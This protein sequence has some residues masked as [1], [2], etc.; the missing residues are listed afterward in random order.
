[1]PPVTRAVTRS[2]ARSLT[3]AASA[4]PP[5]PRCP[6][7]SLHSSSPL[8]PL[9]TS[10][11]T[12][13]SENQGDGASL[14]M[15]QASDEDGDADADG[16]TD[17]E[18]G[19]DTHPNASPN[20]REPKGKEKADSHWGDSSQPDHSGDHGGVDEEDELDEE[21]MGDEDEQGYLDILVQRFAGGP[22]ALAE[23]R[24]QLEFY[25]AQKV[26][27]Q[28]SS[29]EVQR[30]EAPALSQASSPIAARESGVLFDST[31]SDVLHRRESNAPQSVLNEIHAKH[32][33]LGVVLTSNGKGG[34]EVCPAI[35][36]A[37]IKEAHPVP[38]NEL[39]DFM[40]EMKFISPVLCWCPRVAQFHVV[41]G[42]NS[43]A[44]GRTQLRCPGG[45]EGTCGYFVTLEWVVNKPRPVVLAIHHNRKTQ[46]FTTWKTAGV[47]LPEEAAL[48]VESTQNH[49]PSSCA[50]RVKALA[51][52][53][54]SYS[55]PAPS[56]TRM[57]SASHHGGGSLSSPVAGP[58]SF[59]KTPS[60]AKSLA[61]ASSTTASSPVKPGPPET[62]ASLPFTSPS[63][64]KK[65]APTPATPATH[66]FSSNKGTRRP[67]ASSSAISPLSVRSSGVKETDKR[68]SQ[69]RA[70]RYSLQ[71]I[72]SSSSNSDNF[73][74]LSSDPEDSPPP[75]CPIPS[76]VIEI[77]DSDDEKKG[78]GPM[79]KERQT[80]DHR[81]RTGQRLQALASDPTENPRHVLRRR[82]KAV[83][84]RNLL[85]GT[86]L[87]D[88]P[89]YTPGFMEY[90]DALAHT[91]TNTG[92]P[93]TEFYHWQQH[94]SFCPHCDS[95]FWL[96]TG[97]FHECYEG[98]AASELTKGQPGGA[99]RGG[100]SSQPNGSKSIKR[101]AAEEN[102][103]KGKG[104]GEE[105]HKRRKK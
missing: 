24:E 39:E 25:E 28:G 99:T 19:C 36:V 62:R 84:C 59:S 15:H 96:E 80:R 77:T 75:R 44:R 18:G 102:E 57:S 82:T 66:A 34:W 95:A 41:R 65:S 9:P 86:R 48:P 5:P 40:M 2:R 68:T 6:T 3:P 32:N 1:M 88:R 70:S 16:D 100:G 90:I 46:S 56:P 60:P 4:S 81:D 78:Q 64:K 8:T 52:G 91:T 31:L 101:K 98:Q 54:G 97:Q 83:D 50:A 47:S 89:H 13:V 29:V 94:F 7:S 42:P 21:G 23:Q 58:S 26:G 104:K 51:L 38:P 49:S 20:K 63:S 67:V 71:Y 87:P 53:E 73:I 12:H 93:K 33:S 27:N 69:K 103:G 92:I 105:S 30:P 14:E 55:S 72:E 35:Y 79:E 37:A 45:K 17:E 61:K 76:E 11:R 43:P 10:S 22:G 74:E 85:R